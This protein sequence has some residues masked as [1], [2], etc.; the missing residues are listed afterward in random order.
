MKKINAL[1]LAIPL[2]ILA[3]SACGNTGSSPEDAWKNIEIEKGINLLTHSFDKEKDTTIDVYISGYA[4]GYS[5]GVFERDAEPGSVKGPIRRKPVKDDVNIY[6]FN[7]SDLKKEGEYN[8]FL[9]DKNLDIVYDHEIIKVIDDDPTDYGIK[10]ASVSVDTTA[11]LL[12]SRLSVETEHLD[13]HVYY[14]Y[15]AKD[16]I[17]LPNYTFIKKV[18]SSQA[19]TFYVDFNKGMF[20]PNEAS[21]IEIYVEEGRSTSY[22]VDVPNS[23]KLTNST[24]QSTIQVASDIHIESK[25][26][27]KNYNSHFLSS[28]T[29]AKNYEHST[30]GMVFVGDSANTGHKN[31][32]DIFYEYIDS[33]FKTRPT[34]YPIVGNHE[35]QYFD[36]YNEAIATYKENTGMPGAYFTFELAGF[37]CFALGSEDTSTHGIMSETQLSWFRTEIGKLDKNEKI[38]IFMHQGI[39]DTVSGTLPGHGWHG[40]NT[41]TSGI[42]D[43][44]KQYPN[45]F[46]FSGHSHQD[47]NCIQTSLFGKGEEAN[48]VNCGSSAYVLDDSREATHGSTFYFVDIYSDYVLLKGF[49]SIENKWISA[50]NYVV[51]FIK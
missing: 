15:W 11:K 48:Y 14:L 6:S 36:D 43:I 32:Y 20:A 51:P 23:L 18:N 17:R 24:Y 45:A 50:S 2:S 9:F 39:Y 19:S 25:Y 29:M 40:L 34:L 42:R 13:N 35:L 8:L 3:L 37:K 30:S 21:Q 44:V 4:S 47:L 33:V 28:L 1:F 16:N 5:V 12:T 26:T 27:C 22:F 41:K 31:N 7:L 10:N 49:L 38:M 46:V